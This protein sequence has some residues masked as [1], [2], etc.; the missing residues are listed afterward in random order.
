MERKIEAPGW[1]YGNA[2]SCGDWL[3][4]GDSAFTNYVKEGKIPPGVKLSRQLVVWKWETIYA[5][6][7]L[8]PWLT[9]D[10]EDG[11]EPVKR[12]TAKPQQLDQ[13]GG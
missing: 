7:Q 2:K 12:R 11:E 10:D 4:I 8:L 9:G 5:V 6:A 13:T 3:G 1:E